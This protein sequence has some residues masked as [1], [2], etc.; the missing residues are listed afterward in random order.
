MTQL[1]SMGGLREQKMQCVMMLADIRMCNKSAKLY[2]TM[3]RLALVLSVDRRCTPLSQQYGPQFGFCVC[4]LGM[5][6]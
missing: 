3:M 4:I 2:V 5:S 1:T 6:A